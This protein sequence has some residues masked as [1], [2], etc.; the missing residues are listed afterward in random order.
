M[1]VRLDRGAWRHHWLS[2]STLT[3][4]VPDDLASDFKDAGLLAP[5]AAEEMAAILRESLRH[6]MVGDV[7]RTA[8]RLL[9]PKGP[10]PTLEENSGRSEGRA[11][12]D[13]PACG[14]FL[15]RTSSSRR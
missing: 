1:G 6:Y 7:I 11:R 12:G 3:V 9:I 10:P 15:T 8:D 4:T 13:A 5:E 14:W 2:L